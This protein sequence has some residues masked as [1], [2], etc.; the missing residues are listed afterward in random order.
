MTLLR[1]EDMVGGLDAPP[2]PKLNLG[3]GNDRRKGFVNLDVTTQA[4][5]D[6]VGRLGPGALPFADGTFSVVVARDVL[7]HVDVVRGR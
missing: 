6:V 1:F 3:S 5:V 4:D 7:E 2:G